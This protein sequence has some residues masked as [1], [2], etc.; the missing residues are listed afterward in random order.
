MFSAN[1]QAS[2][3]CKF[4]Y[5]TWVQLEENI[6]PL[7]VDLAP[8]AQKLTEIDNVEWVYDGSS[9]LIPSLFIKEDQESSLD[10]GLVLEMIKKQL[11]SAEVDWN[12]YR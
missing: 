7:R 5:E 3:N 8:V 11:N 4:R 1:F 2:S 6:H 9:K 10:A 12:P